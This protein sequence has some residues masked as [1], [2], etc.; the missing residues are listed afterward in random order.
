M[1]GQAIVFYLTLQ[2]CSATAEEYV[3]VMVTW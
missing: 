1:H 2:D 3:R